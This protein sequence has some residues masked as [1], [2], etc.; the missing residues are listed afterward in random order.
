[1]E[2]WRVDGAMS[3]FEYRD[4]DVGDVRRTLEKIQS[5]MDCST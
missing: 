4:S 2:D 3:E 1:M 5:A